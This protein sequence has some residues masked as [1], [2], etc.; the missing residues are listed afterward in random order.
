[1]YGYSF[2][3]NLKKLYEI[4]KIVTSD[5]WHVKGDTCHVTIDTW[6]VTPVGRWTFSQNVMSIVHRVWG[7][8]CFEDIFTKD[9]WI[10]EWTSNKGVCRIAPATP[11]LL[12]IASTGGRGPPQSLNKGTFHTHTHTSMDITIYILNWPRNRW[13]KNLQQFAFAVHL[14]HSQALQAKQK[15]TYQQLNSMLCL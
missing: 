9:V 7:W 12:I 4:Q 14:V 8:M 2:L 11:S 10:I 3:N 1:M 6:H 15:R 5:S 13:S